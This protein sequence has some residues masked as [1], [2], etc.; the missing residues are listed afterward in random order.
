M[1]SFVSERNTSPEQQKYHS[2]ALSSPGLRPRKRQIA[3]VLL[4]SLSWSSM[5]EDEEVLCLFSC[6]FGSAE[7]PKQG[8]N[9]C[10]EVGERLRQEGLAIKPYADNTGFFLQWQTH[11]HTN[12]YTHLHIWVKN[13]PDDLNHTIGNS[14]VCVQTQWGHSGHHNAPS[15]F[16]KFSAAWLRA[17]HFSKSRHRPCLYAKHNRPRLWHFTASKIHRLVFYFFW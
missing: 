1:I 16:Q 15:H 10:Q 5:R 9:H 13:H 6:A 14:L 11:L 2:L 3:L 7:L 8:V 4:F 12:T 17:L